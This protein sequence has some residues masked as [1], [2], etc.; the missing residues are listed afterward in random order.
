MRRPRG[1]RIVHWITAWWARLY[2][3]P[4]VA[5]AIA[6]A[7]PRVPR[8]ARFRAETR[9]MGISYRQGVRVATVGPI[10]AR[11]PA[12][13]IDGV[14]LAPGDRVLVKNEAALSSMGIRIYDPAA[15][16]WPWSDEEAIDEGTMVFVGEGV[17]NEHT[18]WA[19]TYSGF[20][21]FSGFGTVTAGPGLTR[22]G[23]I[24]EMVEEPAPELEPEPDPGPLLEGQSGLEPA[25]APSTIQERSGAAP[26]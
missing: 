16:E 23:A 22:D 7:P 9:Q 21:Q 24:V 11:G 6:P 12:P 20:T 1:L 26:G 17:L 10:V 19:A 4:P 15:A 5:P 18:M 25:L 8:Q 3:E 14:T 2:T 13:P